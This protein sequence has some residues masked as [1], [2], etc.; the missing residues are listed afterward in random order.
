MYFRGFSRASFL[1]FPK[2]FRKL[3]KKG[4]EPQKSGRKLR[5][6]GGTTSATKKNFSCCMFLNTYPGA[7]GAIGS[8]CFVDK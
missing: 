6:K 4:P 5:K 3:L 8:A 1:S 7:S 2:N